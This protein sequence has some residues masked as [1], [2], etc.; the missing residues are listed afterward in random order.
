MMGVGT[1]PVVPAKAG[2]QDVIR[3][4]ASLLSACGAGYELDSGLRRNDEVVLFVSSVL[5]CG[6]NHFKII[7]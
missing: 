2:T 5:I 7:Q 3:C 6:K 4:E 1:K